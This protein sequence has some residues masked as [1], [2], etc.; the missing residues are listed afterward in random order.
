MT[1][2]TASNYPTSLDSDVSLGGDA[3]NLA[4]FT[5]DTSLDASTTTVSVTEDISSINV[6]CYL[7][8]G[9]EL[10]YATAK[11]S[12]NFTT[13]DRGAGGTS[14]ASHSNGDAVYVVYAANL[15]NQL[16]RAVIAIET[17]LGAA[18]S[19]SFATVV[20]R[21]NDKDITTTNIS[22]TTSNVTLVENTVN[23]LTIAGLTANRNTVLPAPSAAGKY[24]TVN[25][26]DGDDT[27]FVILIGDTGVSINGG[28]TATEFHRLQTKGRTAT[29]YSTS[30]TNW[31]LVAG[32]EEISMP[33]TPFLSS[34]GLPISADNFWG[35]CAISY[36]CR[37]ERVNYNYRV[38]T[39]N[40][41]SNYWKID[42]RNGGYT[43]MHT[44]IDTSTATPTTWTRGATVTS[45]SQ[46]NVTTA[47]LHMLGYGYVFGTPGVLYVTG[48][49]VVRLS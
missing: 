4:S 5:L 43:Q 32:C 28:S 1:E 9:S 41:G 17:E 42:I 10:I 37:I 16:K 13:C 6:P 30:T 23:N 22:V 40:D 29:F 14:A 19:G 12:G 35:A 21:L 45:F 47:D 48:T 27:Y 18:P 7:L 8:V 49:V 15:F 3:V 38:D 20:A 39:T 46:R 11:S 31:A 34:T 26:L 44:S 24:I 36:P 33:I 25:I 2:P